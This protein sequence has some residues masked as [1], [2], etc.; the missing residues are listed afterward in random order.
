MVSGDKVRQTSF[1][2]SS[3]IRSLEDQQRDRKED[4]IL[5]SGD[6]KVAKRDYLTDPLSCYECSIPRMDKG[7]KPC[8]FSFAQ[9][10]WRTDE[11]EKRRKYSF[12]F[13]G[14]CIE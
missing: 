7:L 8:D 2:R 12:G 14:H 10:I 3:Q 9:M 5:P 4:S 1:R 11:G 13:R 6:R